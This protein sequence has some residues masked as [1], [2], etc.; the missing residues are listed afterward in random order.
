[1]FGINSASNS[2]ILRLANNFLCLS[3]TTFL[4]GLPGIGSYG[5]ITYISYMTY[6]WINVMNV[7]SF[8]AVVSF[9]DIWIS[10]VALAKDLTFWINQGASGIQQFL[11]LFDDNGSWDSLGFVHQHNLILLWTNSRYSL[12][13]NK[14]TSRFLE[15]SVVSISE[16]IPR[17][18]GIILRTD[19]NLF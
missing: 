5:S 4:G 19:L 3:I 6:F 13:S 14:V 16:N 7:L 10:K 2:S 18:L 1:M 15:S 11:S 8:L 9:I 12:R 17:Y